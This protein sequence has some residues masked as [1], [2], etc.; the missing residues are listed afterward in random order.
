VDALDLRGGLLPKRLTLL[1]STRTPN[2]AGGWTDA[3]TSAGVV[4]GNVTTP[5]RTAQYERIKGEQPTNAELAEIY[6]LE[7]VT[8]TTDMR[9]Q[10]GDRL[11]EIVAVDRAGRTAILI[12]RVV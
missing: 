8:V 6:V 9:I 12:G 11:F 10:D 3:F 1:R 5:R 7:T 2:G 4:Y